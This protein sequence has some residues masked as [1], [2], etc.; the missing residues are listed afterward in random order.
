MGW[1]AHKLFCHLSGGSEKYLVGD[2]GGGG[3]RKFFFDS[4]E[5]VRDA[6]PHTH[7]HTYINNK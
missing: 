4:N 2:R 5:S 6:P 7:T 1:R 3:G